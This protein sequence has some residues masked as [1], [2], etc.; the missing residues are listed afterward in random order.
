MSYK[1]YRSYVFT[2]F[3]GTE[4]SNSVRPRCTY[5]RLSHAEFDTYVDACHVISNAYSDR[6]GWFSTRELDTVFVWPLFSGILVSVVFGLVRYENGNHRQTRRTTFGV[7]SLLTCT[8]NRM[9]IGHCNFVAFLTRTGKCTSLRALSSEVTCYANVEHLSFRGR[10]RSDNWPLAVRR[11]CSLRS[12]KFAIGVFWI[13]YVY[14][15]YYENTMGTMI[16]ACASSRY[17]VITIIN[18]WL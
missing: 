14:N 6:G 16:R 15:G 9:V 4:V 2:L 17:K 8:G 1:Y 7:V 13:Y 12:A 5:N 3:R 18:Q 10:A 11:R